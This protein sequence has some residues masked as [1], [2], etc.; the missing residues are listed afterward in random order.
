MS[1]TI[2]VSLPSHAIAQRTQRRLL[3]QD[4]W[5]ALLRAGS[6]VL[7]FFLWFLVTWANNTW[8]RFYNPMLI[9]T[10]MAV[11]AVGIEMA[12][13]GELWTNITASMYRVVLGFAFAA[14]MGVA[15]GVVV[16]RNRTAASLIEPIVEMFRPVPSLAFL[17]ILVLWF[18]IGETSKVVFIAYASFFPIFTSTRLGMRQID[19]VLVRAAQSMG[20]SR[21]DLF[22]HVEL[23]AASPSILS[24]LRMGFGM[25][26]FVIVAAEF[27]AAE[28]GLGYLINNS[29]TF[30][31]V[32]RM[33]LGAIVIGII[34]FIINIALGRLERR[35]LRWQPK[36]G[37]R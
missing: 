2:P 29:R 17:P 37:A 5:H 34:G 24:G 6:V 18:G 36:P 9:P 7:F 14:V 30:F 25:S 21:R 13:S 8:L 28:S 26:F 15:S 12:R 3:A 22:R 31:D 10:P 16:C 23:P 20:A 32:A 19:P 27:I 4:R 35:A 1:S 11:L 33:L